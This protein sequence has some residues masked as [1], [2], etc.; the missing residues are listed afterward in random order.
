MSVV[1]LIDTI[2]EWAR[3]TVCEHIQLKVPPDDGEPNDGTY[4][5]ELAT[6]AAFPLYVPSSE[7]LPPN[8][9][10]TTPSLCV[11]FLQGEDRQSESSG[12]IEIQFVFSTWDPGFHSKDQFQPNGDGTFKRGANSQTHFQRSLDGWRDAWNFVDIARRAVEN[13]VIIGNEYTIDKVAPVKF[14]P[15]VEQDTITD[16]YPFWFAWLSFKVNYNLRRNVVDYQHL[17]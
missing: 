5:F 17:L 10:S 1:H 9:R 7:K 2:T 12:S 8:I 14:G 15:M 13:T 4:A 3:Q 11:R 6:P 16:Y